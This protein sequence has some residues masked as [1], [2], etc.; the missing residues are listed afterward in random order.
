MQNTSSQSTS[1]HVALITG[2]SQG[3][4]F[5]A[6]SK[7]ASQGFQIVIASRD[8]AAGARAVESIKKTVPGARA[9]W[10][11]LDL[12]S[13][14]SVRQCAQA[15]HARG[16]P[17]H[18][19]INNAG[20]LMGGKQARF[21]ADGFELTFATNH[22]GHFLLTYLLLD[23]LKRSAPARVIAI[24]SQQHIPG[25]AGGPGAR[26]DYGNLKAEK[27]YDARVFY[28]NS[29]LANVWHA[30]EL[31]R[32][33]AAAG[34]TGNALCPGFVPESVAERR[35]GLTRVFYKDILARMPFARSL[36]QAASSI[37][38]LATDPRYATTGG[39]FI[40]DSHE[41]P[42]SPAS[43]DEEQARLLWERSLAWC[44]LS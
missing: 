12:A 29:K 16:Y 6:A 23:D 8:P 5:A 42:S 36:E 2:G 19:M 44:G 41:I 20:G 10:L 3:I 17:L 13:L 25:Y 35:R 11:A 7:L 24:S 30:Y 37:A 27:Y 15:F 32:R 33:Y 4:G 26:F 38:F 28:S 40:F 14:A 21:S 31:N 34:I 22:L 43:Y 9:E 18:V 1:P 39:K